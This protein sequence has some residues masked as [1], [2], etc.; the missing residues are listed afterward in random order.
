MSYPAYIPL[1]PHLPRYLYY[2]ALFAF[3]APIAF[4]FGPNLINFHKLT[5]LS[6]ADFVAE[7]QSRGVPVVQAIKRYQRDH[8]KMPEDTRDLVPDYLPNSDDTNADFDGDW[9][10]PPSTG[11]RAYSEFRFL[12]YSTRFAHEVR[13][14][15]DPHDEHWEVRGRIAHGRIPLLPVTIETTRPAA[16]PIP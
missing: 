3:F 5:R 8:G 13:Y 14:V 7:V 15:F 12:S 9:I 4:Y 6:P 11:T 1:V 10:I 16:R 2:T